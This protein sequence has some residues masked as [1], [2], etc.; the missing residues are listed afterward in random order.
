[1]A[2]AT[3]FPGGLTTF[4]G[5]HVLKS[6]PISTSPSQISQVDDFTP[7]RAGDYSLT[8]TNGAATN[9]DYPSG[10]LKLATTGTTAADI[11]TLVRNGNQAVTSG[12]SYSFLPGCQLWANFRVAYPRTVGNAN[13][14]NINVGLSN[15]LLATTATNGIFFRKA[16]GGTAVNLVIIQNGVSTTFNNVA[17]LALP[18]GLYGDAQSSNAS[19]SAIIAGNSFTGVSVVSGGAGYSVPP[20][21]LTTTTAGGTA[22]SI[23]VW[24]GMGPTS[25]AAN[26]GLVVQSTGLLYGSVTAPYVFNP[27]TGFT[28]N[29]GATT[30]LEVEAIIDLSLYYNGK[31]TLFVGINGR[32]VLSVGS[33][34][35]VPFVNGAT[36]NQATAIGG[37]YFCSSSP[38][39]GVMPFSQAPGAFIGTAPYGFLAP[40]VSVANTTANARSFYLL[41]ETVAVEY[42]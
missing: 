32:V 16:A 23:P 5:R 35:N 17:D 19:L 6:F 38:T 39:T 20:L 25:F 4:P 22:G 28:N 21:V 7:Y 26:T 15:A 10:L 40:L 36:I 3:R 1:M 37:S 34:G 8:Q 33:Q 30:L 29:A 11:L 14:T 12:F 2:N 31:G 27:G 24:A 13:D 9:L 18:S 42:Q 41:E